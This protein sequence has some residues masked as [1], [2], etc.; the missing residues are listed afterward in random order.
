MSKR[1]VVRRGDDWAVVG[2]NADRASGIFGTQAEAINRAREIV[3]NLGGGE[4]T[5]QGRH[6]QWRDSD[7]VPPGP[8]P[9]PPRDK[10]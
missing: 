10:R 7:T 2:P 3:G 6:G 8:D 5:I 4:V 9:C 1:F